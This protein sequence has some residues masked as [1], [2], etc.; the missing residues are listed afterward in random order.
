M[1]KGRRVLYLRL[2]SVTLKASTEI[3]CIYVNP[4]TLL[5]NIV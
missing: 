4:I 1:S 2:I 3:K 5:T